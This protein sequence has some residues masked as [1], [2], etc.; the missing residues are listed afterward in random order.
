MDALPSPR[1]LLL[2][3]VPHAFGKRSLNV[4][5]CR[6]IRRRARSGDL[7]DV[8]VHEPGLAF[9]EGSMRQDLAAGVH[10]LMLTLLLSGARK[11]WVAIPAWAEVLRPWALGRDDLSFCW[12]PIPSTLPVAEA[13]GEGQLPG[14]FGVVVGHF[15]TYQP[16]I[17]D[18]LR[19]L[20]PALLESAPEIRVEL[21]GRGSER[22]A[23]GMRREL[24]A[25][26]ERVTASGELDPVSLSRRLQACDILVQP[27]PDGVSTRRTTLMAA[28]SHGV[29]VVTTMGRLSESIW[30]ESD[31]IVAVPAGDP[32]A[33]SRAVIE[34]ARDPER[35]RRLRAA[36][37]AMYENRFSL[38]HVIS[39]LRAGERGAA[40]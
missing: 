37:R 6:W 25:A 12:L 24:G 38:A 22:V 34:L 19:C 39:A 20:L 27:Y 33:L 13:I 8:M 14:S 29:P 9:R 7:L 15:S 10:R 16:G 4:R 18:P 30:R 3:W 11:V 35:R 26:A 23:E 36:A 5:F 28:M 21:L 1:R 40:A 2:Q 32:A 31:A 17:R